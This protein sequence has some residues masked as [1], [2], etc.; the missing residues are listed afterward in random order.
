MNS[1]FLQQSTRRLAFWYLLTGGVLFSFF[2]WQEKLGLNLALFQIF[3]VIALYHLYRPSFN[4][5]P[6]RWLLVANVI[7]VGA[8]LYQNTAVSKFGCICSMLLLAV[9]VMYHHRSVVYAL[10]SIAT[11]LVLVPA[12]VTEEW[13]A[14]QPVKHRKRITGHWRIF[15]IPIVFVIVFLVIYSS[16]NP[17]VNRTLDW[18]QTQ[19]SYIVRSLFGN[20]SVERVILLI[21]GTYLTA[22]LLFRAKFLYFSNRDIASSENLT[23][24][25]SRTSASALSA[26][27]LG[28][29]ATGNLALKSE[30]KIG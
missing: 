3:L 19:F 11:N 17:V 7:A 1:T 8:L 24:T 23:R 22:A 2:F 4:L 30:Y 9:Y 18:L 10:G 26:F 25:K 14:M 27:L 13:K 12:M 5:I 6:V 28:R 20:F 15:I 29:L 16:A 21:A